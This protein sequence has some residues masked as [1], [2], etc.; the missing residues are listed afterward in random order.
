M[1]KVLTPIGFWLVSLTWGAIMTVIGLLVAVGLIVSGHKPKFYYHLIWFEIGEN[2]GGCGMGCVILT[3][4]NPSTRTIQHEA[5][6]CLQNIIFG[7]VQVLISIVSAIRCTYY[8]YHIKK[9][10]ADKL[11]PYDSAWY[12]Y[13]ASELGRKYFPYG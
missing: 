5:G 4:K 12:E 6:H 1:K 3:G 9:G 13:S 11:K 2:W 8:N 10:M 7:P